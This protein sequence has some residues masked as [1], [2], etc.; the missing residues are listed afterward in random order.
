MDVFYTGNSAY[1]YSNSLHMCLEAAGMPELPEVGLIEC[2]TGMPFGAAFLK[3]NPPLFFPSPLTT[4]PDSGLH[5]ALETMGWTCDIWQGK[6]AKT[7]V[8]KLTEALPQGP[9]LLGPLDMGYLNYDPVASYKRGAD[10]FV[11]VLKIED[12]MV[13]LHDP[14]LYPFAVLPVADLMQAWNARHIGY[15]AKPYTLR[16]HFRP[17]RPVSRAEM[18][19]TILTTIQTLRKHTPHGPVAYGDAQAFSQAAHLLRNGP[20][21]PLASMLTGF[22]LPVGARRCADAAR[23]LGQNGRSSAAALALYKAQTYG[24]AQYHAVHEA[25]EPTANCFAH[26]A[27]LETEMASA[28]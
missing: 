21:A 20:P 23:F 6:D 25:W 13:H 17:V 2:M 16:Y 18:A 28:L 14:Q 9:I 7:A 5:R 4:D 19:E 3:Q 24:R 10:H 27:E 11:V 1:C 26:L 8:T 15:A 12:G 22:A